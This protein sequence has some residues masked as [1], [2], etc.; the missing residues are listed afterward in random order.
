M[1]IRNPPNEIHRTTPAS[2]DPDDTTIL[3]RNQQFSG[4]LDIM[5]A[6]ALRTAELFAEEIDNGTITLRAA[7]A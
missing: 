4:N 7:I 5:T 1:V 6:A 3:R 2:L